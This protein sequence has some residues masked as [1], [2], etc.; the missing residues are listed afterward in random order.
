MRINEFYGETFKG[1]ILLSDAKR[2]LNVAIYERDGYLYKKITP[3]N[4]LITNIVNITT[5][6][7]KL[8]TRNLNSSRPRR[9]AETVSD[10]CNEIFSV[11]SEIDSSILDEN[12]K[13]K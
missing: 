11:L 2:L 9:I 3:S 7:K 1:R 5:E 8:A 6:I 12:T 4:D 10:I 13:G